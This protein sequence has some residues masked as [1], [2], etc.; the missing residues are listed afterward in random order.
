[1]IKLI[2]LLLLLIPVSSAFILD[3]PPKPELCH[4]CIVP[5]NV[6]IM[7]IKEIYQIIVIISMLLVNLGLMYL[8]YRNAKKLD[9][10]IKFDLQYLIYALIGVI[11]GFNW[12]LPNMKYE[13]TYLEIFFTAAA[14]AIAGEGLVN[15]GVKAAKTILESK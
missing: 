11:I 3:V 14:F 7:E 8:M 2:V 12:F 4:D 1:M 15:K 13:G 9:N 6:E 5:R 10:T